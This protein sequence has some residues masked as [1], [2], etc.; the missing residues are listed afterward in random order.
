MQ[1]YEAT[2]LIS[3]EL[4]QEQ[5]EDFLKNISSKIPEKKEVVKPKRIILS[6]PVKKKKEAFLLVLEFKKEAKEAPEL[7]KELEKEK[8]IL[9]LL[10]IK[11]EEKPVKMDKRKT[12]PSIEPKAE[13]KKAEE[14][15]LEKSL[16]EVLE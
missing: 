2:F 12:T 1:K 15:E 8:S 3:P 13:E 4:S 6:Y 5:L 9:R 10:V 11:K 16:K 7:K 14:G